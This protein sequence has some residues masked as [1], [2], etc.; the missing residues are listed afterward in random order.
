[1]NKLIEHKAA[2]WNPH[3][4][5]LDPHGEYANAIPRAKLL[6][7][8]TPGALRLPAWLCE[9]GKLFEFIHPKSTSQATKQWTAFKENLLSLKQDWAEAHERDK[10]EVSIDSPIPFSLQDLS[11]K[12]THKDFNDVKDSIDRCLRDRRMHFMTRPEQD[13]PDESV[14]II[15]Q[16]VSKDHSASIIN[17][18]SVPSEAEGVTVWMLLSLLFEYKVRQSIENRHKDPILVICEE[19]H[20]YVP[21]FG[22]TLSESARSSVARIAK[23]GRKYG[24]GMVVVSQRPS[25]IE[26]TVLSQCSTWVVMRLT[27]PDDQS[28]VKSFMPDGVKGLVDALPGLGPQEAILAGYATNIPSRIRINDLPEEQRPASNDPPFTEGWSS[29]P[30]SDEQIVEVF[31]KWRYNS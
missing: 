3:I 13:N 19:A 4:V 7:P 2:D 15:R 18:S 12:I 24:I 27:N 20:R 23:E 16:F 1:V 6:D 9:A 17:L 25:E 11:D 30:P 31:N 14:D 28:T 29:E 22:N 26:S 10:E 8:T 5:I 21:K